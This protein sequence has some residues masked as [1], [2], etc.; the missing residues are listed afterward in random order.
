MELEG[1]PF[2]FSVL[3]Q[4]NGPH[5]VRSNDF[6]RIFNLIPVVVVSFERSHSFGML[7]SLSLKRTASFAGRRLVSNG[8]LSNGLL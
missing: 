5:W 3:I 6:Y 2:P 1:L 4:F 7:Y 8:L